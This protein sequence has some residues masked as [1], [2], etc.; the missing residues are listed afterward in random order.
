MRLLAG[1][2]AGASVRA[3]L[4]G[5][6]SLSRRPMRRVIEPLTEMGARFDAA[7]RTARRS[8]ST[9]GT[10]TRSTSSRTCRA[11]RSR[12]PCCWPGCT[13]QG[14]TSVTEPAA[15]RD[16]T[17]RALAAFGV[18]VDGR[19][20][21]GLG[22]GRPAPARAGPARCRATSRR[23]R[24]PQVAAAALARLGRHHRRRRAQPEPRRPPRRAA[25]LRRPGGGA[26]RP[27]VAPASRSDMSACGTR[28]LQAVEIVPGGGARADRRAAGA[29]RP[30]HL[31]RRRV[32]VQRRG[33]AAGQ[34]ERSHHGP[35][36]RPARDGGG[37]RRAAR[38]LHRSGP[39]RRLTGGSVDAHGDHRL[40]MA[41]AVAALGATG[42]TT[43]AGADV[44][45]VSYPS[46]FA[47]LDS[48]R[49]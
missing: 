29:R 48:L 26:G 17:E 44:V 35:G 43:I 40:A 49:A 1:V 34:G 5:D 21:P 13:R 22:H 39:A 46:F 41:F 15:T 16:H 25:P 9:A 33:R 42:P 23:R 2:L 14:T 32:T 38:R 10:C 7:R 31:R 8:P 37:C 6:A 30:G 3:T 18:P 27:S 24:S 47:D 19:W 11:R 36:R 4:I 45:A 12:A 20:A 28:E